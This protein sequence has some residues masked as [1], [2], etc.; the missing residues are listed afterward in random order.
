MSSL[1]IFT[2]LLL[3]T[4]VHFKCSGVLGFFKGASLF[5]NKV[6][7]DTGMTEKVLS[8]CAALG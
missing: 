6:I 8:L 4:I 7:L 5:S 2:G 1:G 3:K